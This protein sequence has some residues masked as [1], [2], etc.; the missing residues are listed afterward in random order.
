MPVQDPKPGKPRSVRAGDRIRW[1]DPLGRVEQEVEILQ[2][3]AGQVSRAAARE[4]VHVIA[5]REL[6][7]PWSQER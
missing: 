7:D 4:M 1:R 5:R 3:P 2:L 6:D